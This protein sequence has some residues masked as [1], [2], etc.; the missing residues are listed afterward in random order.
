[1]FGSASK[2]F[3]NWSVVGKSDRAGTEMSRSEGLEALQ[4]EKYLAELAVETTERNRDDD[5]YASMMMLESLVDDEDFSKK[6][7]RE[8]VA[9]NSTCVGGERLLMRWQKGGT[10]AKKRA[11]RSFVVLK[12]VWHW[13]NK[14]SKNFLK[15][16][17]KK[18]LIRS[19]NGRKRCITQGRDN[20]T[21]VAQ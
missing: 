13:N 16:N 5:K 1:M 20:S 17:G 2:V 6:R 4:T 10:K 11:E 15:V 18:R 3:R 14:S 12:S 7:G 21:W 19:R 8:N 9:S